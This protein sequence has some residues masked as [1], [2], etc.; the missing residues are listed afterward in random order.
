MDYRLIRHAVQATVTE[1]IGL[2]AVIFAVG[3]LGA[4][5]LMQKISRP[6]G[7]LTTS[8]NRLASADSL[9]STVVEPG[10]ELNSI[11]AR[12]DEVGQLAR[13]FLQMVREVT[14]REQ[15]L[16]LA[17]ASL[18]RSEAHLRSL[19]ENVTEVILKLDAQGLVTYVSPSVKRV[20]GLTPWEIVGQSLTDHLHLDDHSSWQHALEDA[21]QHA[22]VI[23][24]L[25]LRVRHNDGSWRVVEASLND[26]LISDPDVQS[27]IVTF[28]DITKR[29]QDG[30]SPQ[31]TKIL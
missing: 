7:Q 24:T 11:T 25:V 30:I 26:L 1:M 10:A 15:R 22:G 28:S 3:I 5:L 8:A 23:S 31:S 2:M 6:L 29:T 4:Y 16:T 13:A 17:E 12:S 14:A 18:R 19:I 20:I 21:G 27:I 9:C